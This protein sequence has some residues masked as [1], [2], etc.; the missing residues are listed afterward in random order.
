MALFTF[1]N[2]PLVE[3]FGTLRAMRGLMIAYVL[4]AALLLGLTLTQNGT[5]TRILFFALVALLQSLHV[6]VSANGGALALEPM[7]STAG[8]AAAI[9]G[10]AFFVFGSI[11][12]SF[13]DRLLVDSALPLVAGY[14]IAGAI[15]LVLAFSAR[16]TPALTPAPDVLE[17]VPSTACAD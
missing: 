11:I 17:C 4:V 15:G 10:T 5:P 12:G 3:R 14:V 6:A 1:L 2:A 9:N 7:G 13:I 16:T 8:M